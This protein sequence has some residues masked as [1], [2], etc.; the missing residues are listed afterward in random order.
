[1]PFPNSSCRES[2]LAPFQSRVYRGLVYRH[3]ASGTAFFHQEY[4]GDHQQ[5]GDGEKPE[6]IDVGQHGGLPLCG[7]F[8]QGIGLTGGKSRTCAVRPHGLR[9]ALKHRLEC[10]V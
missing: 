3:S 8:N 4:E 10:R 2:K 1:M 5:D 9:G 6:V 7:A